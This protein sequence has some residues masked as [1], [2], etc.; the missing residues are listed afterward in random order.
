MKLP[1]F[2]DNLELNALR[3]TMGASLRD[4][5]P[6]PPPDALTTEE[7]ERLAGEG[8]EIPL[9][10]VGVLNDGTHIYKGRRV[11]VYIRDVAEYG[12][13]TSMPKYHLAMCNTLS[14]M[15]EAGRF[16]TRYVVATRDDGL[17]NIQK[18]RGDIAIKSDER[19][20]VCQQCLDELNYKSFSMRQNVERRLKAVQGFSIRTFTSV[21]AA[22]SFGCS[23]IRKT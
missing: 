10:E 12:G 19:L 20:N 23:S 13:R 18:I 3:E 8:I 5:A 2:D 1:N 16:K 7:I 9:D 4:Y 14:M 11:I 22:R 17:F 15:M 6:P 21:S